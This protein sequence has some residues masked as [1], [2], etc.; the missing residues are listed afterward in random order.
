MIRKARLSRLIPLAGAAMAGGLLLVAAEFGGGAPARPMVGIVL[1]AADGG[2]VEA[3]VARTDYLRFLDEERARIA[4]MRDR[5]RALATA[6]IE[7]ELAAISDDMGKGL[8]DYADWYFTWGT[9]HTVVFTAAKAYAGAIGSA[10]TPPRDAA[11][12]AMNKVFEDKFI[13]LVLKP[14]TTLPRL[15]AALRR[16]GEEERQ[17]FA[18]AVIGEAGEMRRFV[19]AAATSIT[20]VTAPGG[21]TGRERVDWTSRTRQAA[22]LFGPD[23]R[24]GLPAGLPAVGAVDFSDLS[25]TAL[26]QS[27]VNNIAGFTTSMAAPTLTVLDSGATVSS[28][29]VGLFGPFAPFFT[30]EM[31]L[32]GTGIAMV[33][34]YGMVKAVEYGGRGELLKSAR[35]G[36]DADRAWL[37]DLCHRELNSYSDRLYTGLTAILTGKS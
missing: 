12:A 28:A 24:S 32:A 4:A 9:T 30:P 15:A 18:V 21:G 6:A 2:T 25:R 31:L 1:A 10:D 22:A 33:T 36:L 35:D 16:I 27:A 37:S 29:L 19:D 17:A 5:A 7:R 23:G 8:E 3:L 13:E 14:E 34:D 26:I 20:P 11:A